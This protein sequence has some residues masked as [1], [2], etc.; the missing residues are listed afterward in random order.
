MIDCILLSTPKRLQWLKKSIKSIDSLKFKFN[1]KILSVDLIDDDVLDNIFLNE[2]KDNGWVVDIVRF[3]NKHLSFK[4]AVDSSTAE[5][6]FYTEDD[7]VIN[8]VPLEIYN[9]LNIEYKNKK[10][11]I[12]SFNLGGSQ[13]RYPYAFG[14]MDSIRERII[15]KKENIISFVRD[16]NKRNNF[17]VEFP[18]MFIKKE[19]ISKLLSEPTIANNF[20]ESELS[21]RYFS[22]HS[23]DVY[24][25]QCM[26]Y[27]KIIEIM[28]YLELNKNLPIHDA[29]LLMEGCKFYKLLDPN[30]GGYVGG[31]DL[32]KID[33][34]K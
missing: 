22:N 10:C 7:I 9:I 1:K 30:Q 3:K 33:Y 31:L 25:K 17:F 29:D 14:D 13:L 4:H 2:L 5:Y 18:A 26:C 28:D 32:N 15:F 6:I 16:E 12:L 8:N 27:D 34:V 24:F 20:I 11:G 21:N 19:L 23:D